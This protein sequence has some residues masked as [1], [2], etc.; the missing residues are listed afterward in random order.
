MEKENNHGI[1]ESIL[2]IMQIYSASVPGVMVMFAANK[3][4]VSVIWWMLG[5][6]LMV[7]LGF[8]TGAQRIE[9]YTERRKAWLRIG[10]FLLSFVSMIILAVLLSITYRY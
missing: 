6:V 9:R 10:V 8:C 1:K 5:A 7:L 4:Q 3:L 2:N